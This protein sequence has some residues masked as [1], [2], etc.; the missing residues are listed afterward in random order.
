VSWTP[1]TPTANNATTPTSSATAR[2]LPNTSTGDADMASCRASHPHGF[3]CVHE[4]ASVHGVGELTK[5][6][7]DDYVLS[8]FLTD[9]QPAHRRAQITS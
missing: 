1:V 4:V 2:L 6:T 5:L 9:Y 8:R 7:G 3:P